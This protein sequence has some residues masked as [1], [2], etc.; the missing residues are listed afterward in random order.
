MTT[1]PADRIFFGGDIVTIDARATLAEAV[2]ITAGRISA[3][4]KRDDT[5]AL[6]GPDTVLTDLAGRA[7]LPGLIDA[8]G[9]LG[10]TGQKLAS[11]DLS[12]QPIGPVSSISDLQRELRSQ[13]DRKNI[14]PA[15][16]VVG[17]G[18]DDTGMEERRH[19]NRADLDGVSKDH[20]IV[21]VHVSGHLMGVNTMALEM[22]G[23]S[24][25]TPDP[26][27]GHFRRLPNGEP[28]GVL[29]ETAMSAIFARLPQPTPEE[30]ADQVLAASDYYASRG[31]TTAQEAALYQPSFVA[32]C[33]ALD[34]D[35][36]LPIDIVA[37]PLL[38]YARAM[39]ASASE[40]GS[41]FRFGGMKVTTDG[42]IQGYTAYLSKPYHI[43][44]PDKRDYAGFPSFETQDKL[45][46][47]ILDG[48]E[49]N[50]QVMAHANGD[51]A[52]DMVIQAARVAEGRYPGTDRRTTIIHAQTIREDQLDQ[53]ARL[54]VS[55]S[56]FPG[57]VYYW[58]DRHRDVFLGPDRAA[59]IN[60][61]RSALA[62][63]I[64]VTLHHD[65]PV[66]PPDIL[67]VVWAAVNRITSAGLDLGL[68][69]RLTPR[70]A[71]RAVTIDAAR[72]I[73]EE[74]RKGSIEVGKLADLVLLSANPLTV[75]PMSIRDIAIEETIKEGGT[76]WQRA[77]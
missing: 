57:H 11:A 25:A 13:I 63:G 4:G 49:N 33:R 47:L 43:Q 3:V 41:R 5:I 64:P 70:E 9:H 68:N 37:Y 15:D 12:P 31:A 22:A 51:A 30:A 56:F 44:P 76:I 53:V 24:A 58:G 71:I 73:F 8:H 17:M 62:R 59:G 38:I 54:G 52:I 23:V 32:A 27:G 2:A 18:Y 69:Q 46:A 55:L 75:P 28:D 39:L 72:Q 35:M 34:A 77:R 16:W 45:N 6:A 21:T 42:S 29:E 50:W 19:P 65:S 20:P 10:M 48:Y 60:P 36:R 26:E 1:P 74:D 67:T 61:M 66:T 14:Q 40:Q 7:L